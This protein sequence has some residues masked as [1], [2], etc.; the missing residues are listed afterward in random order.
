[1]LIAAIVG[2]GNWGRKI[3]EAGDCESSP[4]RIS[5]AVVREIRDDNIAFAQAHA[6]T[7]VTDLRQVLK[8]PAIDAVMIAT[9]HSLHADQIVASA[10]AGKHVFCEKP[11]ALRQVDAM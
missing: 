4:L 2:L 5:H 6:I 1:M 9:P 11:L 7:P 3:V 8:D 10:A